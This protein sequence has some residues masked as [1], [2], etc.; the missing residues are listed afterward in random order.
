MCKLLKEFKDFAVKGDALS[1]AVGLMIGSGFSGIVS[2]VVNDLFMPVVGL[3][4]GGVDFSN[5]FLSLNGQ[6]YDTLDQAKAAGAPVLAYGSFLTTVLDFVLLALCVFVVVKLMNAV[7]ERAVKPAPAE[8]AKQPR[9][10][11]YCYG[12]VHEKATRCAHCG[13]EIMPK[14]DEVA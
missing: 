6:H 1:M 7:K 9:L 8:P 4:T 13:A 3:I 11:P 12:E 14:E 2:S 10:C 5:L